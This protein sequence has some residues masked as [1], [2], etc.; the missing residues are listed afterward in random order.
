MKVVNGTPN[1]TSA[2]FWTS[3]HKNINQHNYGRNNTAQRTEK[4]SY[5]DSLQIH[6]FLTAR[7]NIRFTIASKQQ[8][9]CI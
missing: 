6:L 9:D 1:Q 4:N 5:Q 2:T 7:S 8:I 3:Q